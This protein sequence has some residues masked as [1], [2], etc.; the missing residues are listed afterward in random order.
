[1][2]YFGQKSLSSFLNIFLQVSYYGVLLVAI[3]SGILMTLFIYTTTLDAPCGA[4]EL[5]CQ[6]SQWTDEMS[7]AEKYQFEEFRSF[8]DAPKL[9]LAPWFIA[10]VVLLL[11]IIKSSRKLFANF[12]DEVVFNP[13]NVEIIRK[14]AKLILWYGI[15][16]F[17][18]SVLLVSVLLWMLCEIFKSG[19]ALQEEHDLTV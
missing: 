5:F 7:P 12:K 13:A 3:F 1:M 6:M 18:F 10:I 4:G 11:K 16:T 8:P 17:S 15:V 14:T 2:K 9:L 19:A